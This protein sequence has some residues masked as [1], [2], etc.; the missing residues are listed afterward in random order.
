MQI[1]LQEIYTSCVRQK[2]T[3]SKL[4]KLLVNFCLILDEEIC[5]NRQ[6]E[7]M[8]KRRF[9]NNCSRTGSI[10]QDNKRLRP[11]ESDEDSILAESCS[12]TM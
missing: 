9:D 8:D 2:K 1:N 3:N 10:E 12:R 5:R 4:W 7:R 6:L 11:C